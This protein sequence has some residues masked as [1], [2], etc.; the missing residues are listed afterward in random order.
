MCA[1]WWVMSPAANCYHTEIM[2]NDEK[3]H[4]CSVD[5]QHEQSSELGFTSSLSATE[6]NTRNLTLNDGFNICI[7]RNSEIAPDVFESPETWRLILRDDEEP[8]EILF[9]GRW[10]SECSSDGRDFS[11][12]QI[13]HFNQNKLSGFQLKIPFFSSVFILFSPQKMEFFSPTVLLG[14]KK[15]ACPTYICPFIFPESHLVLNY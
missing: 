7:Q 12:K 10:L 9:S 8:Q 14:G 11:W 13:K 2:C 15:K 5:A 4:P 6:E 1:W 3:Q